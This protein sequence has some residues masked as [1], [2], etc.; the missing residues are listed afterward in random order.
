M[1]PNNR[2]TSNVGITHLENENENEMIAVRA[3][4]AAAQKM[5]NNDPRRYR[6]AIMA[7]TNTYGWNTVETGA[8]IPAMPTYPAPLPP[9]KNT[10]LPLNQKIN[11][12]MSILAEKGL[13]NARQYIINTKVPEEY[14]TH[15]V[16]GSEGKITQEK[17][18]PEWILAKERS[19]RPRGG[20]TLRKRKTLR[21]TRSNRKQRK[22]RR[23]RKQ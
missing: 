9:H 14:G 10:K 8:P 13:K 22:T 20:R 16:R 21:K 11:K 23:N 18:T 4:K 7:T 3:S 15:E 12:A 1:A 2:S 6:D 5:M 17:Y 19:K